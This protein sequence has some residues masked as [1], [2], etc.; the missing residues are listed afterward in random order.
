M[1]E[2]SF[3]ETSYPTDPRGGNNLDGHYIWSRSGWP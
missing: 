1:L 3:R 2:I